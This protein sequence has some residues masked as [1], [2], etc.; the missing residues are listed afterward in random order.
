MIVAE[1]AARIAGKNLKFGG[2]EGEGGILSWAR[3]MRRLM[4][5]RD[6][7]A[8]LTVLQ[9]EED[10]LDRNSAAEKIV[11]ENTLS[12]TFTLSATS[13]LARPGHNP[14]PYDSDDSLTG[15]ASSSSRSPSPSLEDLKE[16]EKDPTLNVGVKKVPRPVYLAQLGELLR[17]QPGMQTQ[18][19]DEPHEADRIEMAVNVAEELIRRKRDYGT[20]LGAAIT[21]FFS[22][23]A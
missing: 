8:D 20:E 7:D 12:S 16:I 18:K 19:P 1:E 11:M 2:W 13:T 21:S 5:A 23:I 15:Y 3:D 6:V 17:G 4:K 10:E 22:T 14:D 9:E